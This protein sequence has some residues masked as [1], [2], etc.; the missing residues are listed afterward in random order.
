VK[1][2]WQ[3]EPA[4]GIA[5]LIGN[6]GEPAARDRQVSPH[7]VSI[8]QLFPVGKGHPGA[9]PFRSLNATGRA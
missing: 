3:R 2:R 7:L 5:I 4:W 1:H 8:G 6:R 9:F